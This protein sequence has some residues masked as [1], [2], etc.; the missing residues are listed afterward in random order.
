[1]SRVPHGLRR[2]LS[3]KVVPKEEWK[4][5]TIKNVEEDGYTINEENIETFEARMAEAVAKKEAT[6]IHICGTMFL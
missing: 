4:N 3:L 6:P 1:M 5:H 2:R